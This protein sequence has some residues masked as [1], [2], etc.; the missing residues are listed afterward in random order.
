VGGED[1]CASVSWYSS[2]FAETKNA[3]CRIVVWFFE[4]PHH[5]WPDG[6][7]H[8]VKLCMYDSWKQLPRK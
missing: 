8:I 1:G 6:V 5:N 2:G 4:L 3:V 7:L